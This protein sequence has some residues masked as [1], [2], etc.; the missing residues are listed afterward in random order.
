MTLVGFYITSIG[1]GMDAHKAFGNN[2]WIALVLHMV[3]V[4]VIEDMSNLKDVDGK[5]KR[6]NV[7]YSKLHSH[8]TCSHHFDPINPQTEQASEHSCLRPRARI[9]VS[10]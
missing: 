2:A 9:P 4:L 8:S 3:K 10:L 7:I 6:L 1:F 5:K